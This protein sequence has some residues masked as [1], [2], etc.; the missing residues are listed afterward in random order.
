M[1]AAPSRARTQPRSTAPPRMS[2]ATLR[3]RSLP[4]AL[5]ASAKS[6]SPTP[7]ASRSPSQSVSRPSAPGTES[8]AEIGKRLADRVRPDPEGHHRAPRPAA[9]HLPR[10]RPQRPFRQSRRSPGRTQ[11][12]RRRWFGLNQHGLKTRA[13]GRFA[14]CPSGGRFPVFMNELLESFHPKGTQPKVHSRGFLTLA[15]RPKQKKPP[16]PTRRPRGLWGLCEIAYIRRTRAL[17]GS[18]DCRRHFSLHDHIL[19]VRLVHGFGSKPYHG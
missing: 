10:N 14:G 19:E 11:I 3:S 17:F 12:R 1:A 5:P 15:S 8:D 18:V 6:S 13:Y 7:L 4:R 9:P 2:R 16:R